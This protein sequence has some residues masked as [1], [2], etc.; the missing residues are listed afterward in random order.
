MEE[1]DDRHNGGHDRWGRDEYASEGL[2]GSLH[3]KYQ[4]IPQL[5]LKAGW[6]N[7]DVPYIGFNYNV[8]YSLPEMI[9]YLSYDFHLGYS[10]SETERGVTMMNKLL[11]DFAPD[12]P[13]A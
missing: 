13:A 12:A 7:N 10:V 1:F 9:N 2:P 8:I 11:M 3:V 5:W 4:F 6:S